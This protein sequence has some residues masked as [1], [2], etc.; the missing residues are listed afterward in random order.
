VKRNL[1]AQYGLLAPLVALANLAAQIPL[2]T[3]AS[4]ADKAL[5]QR[6]WKAAA[7]FATPLSTP[8]KSLMLP[9]FEATPLTY[10]GSDAR[11]DLIDTALYVNDVLRRIA[12]MFRLEAN[13]CDVPP[14]ESPVELWYPG[15]G[16]LV[17]LRVNPLDA[18]LLP[19][20][21]ATYKYDYIDASR[22]RVCPVCDR[23]F[24]AGRIDAMACGYRCRLTEK[25]RRH[26]NPEKRKNYRITIKRLR[27]ARRGAA[28]S[29]RPTKE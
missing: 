21:Q 10:P 27:T 4:N 22:L 19:A 7:G 26:D 6:V 5:K 12:T 2:G 15:G 8:I 17:V 20:L 9:G 25:K 14:Y 13:I 3:T 18:L 24:I 16:R 28:R 29:K 23:L 11:L 1:P